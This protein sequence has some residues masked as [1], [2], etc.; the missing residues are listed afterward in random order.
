VQTVEVNGSGPGRCHG[1]PGFKKTSTVVATPGFRL[2][3]HE[4]NA[5]LDLSKT[6]L[7]IRSTLL[8]VSLRQPPAQASLP[9]ATPNR[10]PGIG[11]LGATLPVLKIGTP[12]HCR[13]NWDELIAQCGG[14]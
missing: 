10:V 2:N 3:H 14:C 6:S 11:R 1:Q 9:A 7:K 13:A 4:L 12:F 5:K 8:A